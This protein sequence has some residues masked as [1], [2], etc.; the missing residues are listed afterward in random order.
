[1]ISVAKLRATTAQAWPG[2]VDTRNPVGRSAGRTGRLAWMLLVALNFWLWP[3]EG[4]MATFIHDLTIEGKGFKASGQITISNA[5]GGE[6]AIEDFWLKG[7]LFGHEVFWDRLK[8]ANF[9]IDETSWDMYLELV[10]SEVMSTDGSITATPLPYDPPGTTPLWVFHTRESHEVAVLCSTNSR[11]PRSVR[12]GSCDGQL[13]QKTLGKSFAKPVHAV[14]EPG[15][16]VLL[17]FGLVAMG[18]AGRR[19]KPSA[20]GPRVARSARNVGADSISA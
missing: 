19:R 20:S 12:G 8:Y 13:E 17:S 15:T 2:R 1:M 3:L 7:Q 10:L 9:K 14:P 16:L 11:D 4:A 18:F 6:L 5:R